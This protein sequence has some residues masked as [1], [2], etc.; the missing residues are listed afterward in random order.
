MGSQAE[1]RPVGSNATCFI[2]AMCRC[3]QA[4]YTVPV[5]LEAEYGIK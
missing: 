2:K 1:S 4:N 3:F 5:E